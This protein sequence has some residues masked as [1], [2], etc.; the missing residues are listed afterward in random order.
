[1]LK[2]GTIAT[3]MNAFTLFGFWGLFSWI[4]AYLSLPVSQG[5][6][7]IGLTK[8]T[9]FFLILC[10][11][12]W[13]GYVT[14]GFLADAFGRR[15]PYFAYLV[16]AAILVPLYGITRDERSLLLL[17]PI[18]AFFGTGYFSGY[19]AIASEIFPGAI[20]ATAMG[21]SYNIGRVFS[22]IAPFAIGA[23]AI[24]H[25]IGPAFILL[26]AAFMIAALLSLALPET[27]ARRLT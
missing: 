9:A 2:A 22:A 3:V 23:L 20:R 18:V 26:A 16:I 17:G 25:G 1:V 7:G 8:T 10:I 27:R 19:P 14:F 6:R 13:L 15:K 11:G 21:F 5:G 12:K 4:P 24:R